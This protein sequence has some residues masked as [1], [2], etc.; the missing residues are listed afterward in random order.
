MND[1]FVFDE[2]FYLARYPDVARAVTNGD[3]LSGK[4]H[5]IIYGMAEG[6]VAFSTVP[7]DQPAATIPDR[8]LVPI[9]VTYIPRSGSTFLMS[10][11]AKQHD[12]VV[13][14]HY[15]YE[16]H[17]AHYYAHAGHVLTSAADHEYSGSPTEFMRNKHG[18]SFNPFDHPEFAA[19]EEQSF[20]SHIK[21][22][23]QEFCRAMANDYYNHLSVHQDR[24]NANSFCREVRT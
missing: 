11:L 9:I 18:L 4:H 10:I 15:P 23:T 13:A 16:V 2:A 17:V 19:L 3:V 7:T 12:I 14:D 21:M 22:R 5:Y 6:R 8:D 24:P 20:R 1:T